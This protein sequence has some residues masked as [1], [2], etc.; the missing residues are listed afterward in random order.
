MLLDTTLREG[1]QAVG[2]TFT[3]AR[4]RLLL[5][6]LARAGVSE[7]EVGWAGHPELAATVAD[8]RRLAPHLAIGIWCRAREDDLAKAAALRPDWLAVGLPVSDLHLERR[9]G[10][11]RRW[12]I[13]Q[14]AVLAVRARTLGVPVA[15]GLEDATR[16]DPAVVASVAS[17]AQAAGITRLRLADTCGIAGPG[18]IAA[19]VGEVRARFGG[20]VG[21]HLHDD[22]GQA[23]G[24]A[25]AGFEAGA[26]RC[27]GSLL[28]LGERA[29]ICAT[30]RLAAWSALRHGRPF[31]RLAPLL[32]ACRRLAGW[33]G[34]AIDVDR[35]LLGQGIFACETGIHL[36]G[37]LQDPRTFEPYDPSAVGA[38][39]AWHGGWK[40]GRAGARRP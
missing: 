6:A 13:G 33:T 5:T 31:P 23:M 24:N 35:P 10:R 2:V 39:R 11:D 17:G 38:R 18:Q 27:D 3:P 29:G 36:H 22:F 37:L 1:E 8:A 30:E 14:P 16:A 4:R 34:R 15:L 32:A 19:L 9:L 40:A 7:A 21:L 28:G 12:A 20:L 26:D 25:L